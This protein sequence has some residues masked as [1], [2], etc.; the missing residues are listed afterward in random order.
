MENSQ[1]LGAFGSQLPAQLLA[2]QQRLW[3]QM[4]YL[5]RVVEL[6]YQTRVGTT[7]HQVVLERGPFKLVRYR[8]EAPAAYAEP[9]L[10][11]YA[12][13]N[14]PYILDLLPDRSVVRRYL[15]RGFDVYLI[16]WSVPTDADRSLSLEDYVCRFLA[17]AVAFILAQ[18]RRRTLHLLGYCMGGTM[19][20]LFT[21][22]EPAPI[23]TL[24][25][26]AAPIDFGG[27]E[28]LLQVWSDPEWFDVDALV[29]VYG[30]CPAWFLQSCFLLTKPIQNFLEKGT[31]LYEQMDNAEMV[32]HY[33]AMERWIND[34]VPV[35][36]ETFRQFVKKLYQ[37][38]ELVR[39]EFCLADR[40]VDLGR[41]SCPLLLLTA[42]QDHLV[43]PPATEGLRSHVTSQ[44]IRSI[45][46]AAGHVGLVVGAKAQRTLWPEATQWLAE[47][48]T[49]L[50]A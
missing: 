21:A 42:G 5:P 32:T 9:V 41:I 39:G 16:D 15:E 50:A 34:N 30:N 43:A 46:I 33:F 29:D 3:Q 44:D 2:E 49:A 28:S 47:R 17:E 19:S 31:S 40:R 14:R 48:S 7:P 12:L 26:L 10:F 23:R 24:T 25:L 20:A 38:N 45:G 8:R 18:H 1:S 4:L 35:A 6:A 22:L 27:R 36:G 37:R 11:C 13:I